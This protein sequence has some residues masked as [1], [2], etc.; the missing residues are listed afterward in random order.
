MGLIS[1]LEK[2]ASECASLLCEKRKNC[3]TEPKEEEERRQRGL[4]DGEGKEGK[5]EKEHQTEAK[6]KRDETGSKA[7]RYPTR[8]GVLKA[9]GQLL[10]WKRESRH[11]HHPRDGVNVLDFLDRWQKGHERERSE[12]GASTRPFCR[13]KEANRSTHLLALRQSVDHEPRPR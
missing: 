10:F 7:E 6:K 9:R 8:R 4:G 13:G 11:H 5:A 12:K 3:G 1:T 2:G